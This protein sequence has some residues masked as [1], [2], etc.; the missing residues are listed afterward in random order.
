[1][2]VSEMMKANGY[3]ID[4][5]VFRSYIG[6]AVGEHSYSVLTTGIDGQQALKAE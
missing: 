4:H 5:V 6:A 2:A 3:W 1:M